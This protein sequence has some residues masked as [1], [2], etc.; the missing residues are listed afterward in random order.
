MILKGIQIKFYYL[1]QNLSI[2][3]EH[4]CPNVLK[5]FNLLSKSML[6]ERRYSI[7]KETLKIKLFERENADPF[8]N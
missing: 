5:L 8:L 1:F 4:G 7:S 3:K 2:T 6:F